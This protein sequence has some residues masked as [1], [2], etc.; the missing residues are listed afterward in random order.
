[1]CTHPRIMSGV[2]AT[3]A[4][5]CREEKENEFLLHA[6]ARY[7]DCEQP[8]KLLHDKQQT[9]AVEKVTVARITKKVFKLAFMGSGLRSFSPVLSL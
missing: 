1:M 5:V 4:N 8:T 7:H 6:H 9:Q 3:T 2:P